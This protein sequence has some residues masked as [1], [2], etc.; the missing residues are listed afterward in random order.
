M[1]PLWGSMGL[2]MGAVGLAGGFCG[3]YG[4]HGLTWS[5]LGLYGVPMV[6]MGPMG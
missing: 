6:A 1:V 2:S 5:P 3:H 4:S